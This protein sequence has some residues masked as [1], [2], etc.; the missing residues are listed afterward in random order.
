MIR[1]L[2]FWNYRRKHDGL[3]SPEEMQTYPRIGYETERT[4]LVKHLYRSHYSLEEIASYMDV[5][6]E[7]IRWMV[8]KIDRRYR[9]IGPYEKTFRRLTDS[10]YRFLRRSC[11]YKRLRDTDCED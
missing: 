10:V 1:F 11:L 4:I 3:P 6:R 5:P 2:R 9:K 7:R 8:M